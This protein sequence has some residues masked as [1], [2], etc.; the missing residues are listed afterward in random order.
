[1]KRV[2]NESRENWQNIAFK[3]R[4]ATWSKG[5]VYIQRYIPV[6][7][8]MCLMTEGKEALKRNKAFRKKNQI[9]IDVEI[10]EIKEL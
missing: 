1:M 10:E 8:G 5:A 2:Q 3:C 9:G 7:Q 6:F 4:I